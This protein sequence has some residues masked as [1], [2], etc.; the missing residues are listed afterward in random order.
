MNDQD[1]KTR[2]T[3]VTD[4]AQGVTSLHPGEL[5]IMIHR[6]TVQDDWKGLGETLQEREDFGGDM[7][8]VSTRHFLMYNSTEEGGV[9]NQHR[10]RQYKLDR[11]P[12]LWFA[13]TLVDQFVASKKSDKEVTLDLQDN[14]KLYV[15]SY[16]FNEYVVK[17]HNLDENKAKNVDIHDASTKACTIL[18]ALTGRDDL[19]LESITELSLFTHK[20][21]SDVHKNKLDPKG[22][23]VTHN[24]GEGL[25]KVELVPMEIRTFNIVLVASTSS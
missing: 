11:P 17:L 5:E 7:L 6:L 8:K 16:N 14:V 18:N 12:Q 19:K 9:P 1:K 20:P 22:K 13:N 23:E 4:R 24:D 2:L 3:V 10:R 25:S 15:R 21:R